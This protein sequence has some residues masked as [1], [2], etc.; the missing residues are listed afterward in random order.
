MWVHRACD[1][2]SIILRYTIY[3]FRLSEARDESSTRE[4]LSSI[5]Q[6][7]TKK[8][9][10]KIYKKATGTNA[11]NR[12]FPCR[13]TLRPRYSWRK[14]GSLDTAKQK[15]KL[16]VLRVRK[17]KGKGIGPAVSPF[18]LSLFSFLSLSF[19]LTFFCL[20]ISHSPSLSRSRSSFFPRLIDGQHSR[21]HHALVLHCIW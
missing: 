18:F 10:T 15:R 14:L 11:A 5:N 17:A 19:Y 9:P 7:K 8:K 21:E 13:D 4:R 12:F 3:I 16:L 1:R 2:H 6:T 20:S